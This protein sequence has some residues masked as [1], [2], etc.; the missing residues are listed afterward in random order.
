MDEAIDDVAI[1]KRH[2][3]VEAPIRRVLVSTPG[4][5]YRR[6]SPSSQFGFTEE[7][8]DGAKVFLIQECNII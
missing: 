4:D 8:Y 7:A 1:L 5:T 3:D 2:A 6:E